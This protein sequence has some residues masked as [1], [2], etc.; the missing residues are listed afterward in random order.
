MAYSDAERA[1][2]VALAQHSGG[3]LTV[4][5]LTEI[6]AA[7]GRPE[8]SSRTIRNWLASPSEIPLENNFTDKKTIAQKLDSLASEALDAFFERTARAYLEH[9]NQAEVIAETKG[10]QAVTA[11]AIAVDKMRLLRDLPT[12]IVTLLPGVLRALDQLQLRPAD[13]FQSIIE[14]AA[15]QHD[16]CDD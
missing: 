5:V 2:A 6:R 15:A 12:E 13:G 11:A 7:I 8:I 3:K 10:P 1:I 4:D 9:A 14:E 16:T